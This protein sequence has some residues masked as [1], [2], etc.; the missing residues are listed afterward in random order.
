M[1]CRAARRVMTSSIGQQCFSRKHSPRTGAHQP[2]IRVEPDRVSH[3]LAAAGFAHDE[4][5]AGRSVAQKVRPRGRSVHGPHLAFTPWVVSG[6]SMPPA[7][8][9]R[10]TVW[11]AFVS[12]WQSCSV[13]WARAAH[14]SK[15][16]QRWTRCAARAPRGDLRCVGADVRACLPAAAAARK[17][18]SGVWS[19]A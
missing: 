10:P 4:R 1:R 2:Y 19:T 12:R 16:S 7:Q 17:T 6:A 15:S 11:R 13:R 8:A 14:P 18:S 3:P 5:N 9:G